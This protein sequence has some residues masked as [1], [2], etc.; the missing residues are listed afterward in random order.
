MYKKI[1]AAADSSEGSNIALVHAVILAKKLGAELTA[2]WVRGS[3]PHYPETVDEI[4]EEE[5]TAQAF[6]LEIKEHLKSLSATYGIAIRAELRKGHPAQQVVECAREGAFN[7]IVLGSRGHS[8]LWGQLLG[9]TADR[10]NEYAPCSVLIVRSEKEKAQYR[11]ML[12]GFDGSEGG[13][14]ALH[15]ALMIGKAISSEVRVLWI[16][17]VPPGYGSASEERYDEKWMH[18]FFETSVKDR[19]EQ[20]A[21]ECGIKVEADCRRGFADKTLVTEAEAGGFR[22]IVLGHSGHSGLWGRLLGGTA[23]RVSHHAHCDVLIVREK[24]EPHL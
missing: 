8:R 14:T 17:E 23:D 7:L 18:D 20:A 4:E 3:L 24:K 6:F 9:H 19:I 16:H 11:R 1:L 10:V 2:L 5:E 12:V 22:L 15:H 21:S 13:V